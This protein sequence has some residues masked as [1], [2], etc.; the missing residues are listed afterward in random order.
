MWLPFERLIVAGGELG[1]AAQAFA[2]T[3][4]T[5]RLPLTSSHDR[6]GTAAEFDCSLHIVKGHDRDYRCKQI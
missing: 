4:S 3:R 5:Q 2:S 1:S 6:N